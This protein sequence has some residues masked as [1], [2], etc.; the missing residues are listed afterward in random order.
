MSDERKPIETWRESRP[1]TNGDGSP[2][3]P[4]YLPA[5]LMPMPWSPP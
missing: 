4:L 1:G 2:A 3:H 5:S